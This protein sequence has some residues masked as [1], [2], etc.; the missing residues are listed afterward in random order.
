MN[1]QKASIICI[2]CPRGCEITLDLNKDG[3]I[4]KIN[5]QTCK[6]GEEYARKELTNPERILTSTVKVKNGE[7]PVVSVW[8]SGP[9]PKE[10]IL[11]VMKLLDQLEI[12]APVEIGDIVLANPLGLAINIQA[13]ASILKA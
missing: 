13:S 9:L 11:P 8:S 1:N 10:K 12:E 5:G 4:T 6:L 3:I 7:Y 2:R